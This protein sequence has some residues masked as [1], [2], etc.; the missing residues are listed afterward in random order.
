M[1]T[2]ERFANDADRG[3]GCD[4]TA[5]ELPAEAERDIEC[6]KVGGANQLVRDERQR[7]SPRGAFHAAQRA[8]F[9]LDC[10]VETRTSRLRR[11]RSGIGPPGIRERHTDLYRQHVGRAASGIDTLENNERA[12]QQPRAAGSNT[13]TATCTTAS[14]R[15]SRAP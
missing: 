1:E 13:E 2:N 11:I 15:R 14:A 6:S 7:A 10:V 4:V 9:T 5:V 8:D 12:Q 3:A